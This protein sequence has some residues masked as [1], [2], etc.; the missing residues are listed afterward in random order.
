M[1]AA[2]TEA[3]APTQWPVTLDGE[4]L[5]VERILQALNACALVD[6][7]GDAPSSLLG[8]GGE[9]GVSETTVEKITEKIVGT[10]A[11]RW[12]RQAA[13][14][15]LLTICIEE[16]GIDIPLE[17]IQQASDRYREQ[18]GLRSVEDT[19]AW[20]E[21]RGLS[22][23]TWGD[24]V[25]TALATDELVRL[26]TETGVETW[27]AQ[28]RRSLDRVELA[29]LAVTDAGMAEEIMD[30]FEDG[31]LS[32]AEAV[33]RFHVDPAARKRG[34]YLGW[35]D[36]ARVPHE[37]EARLFGAAP[38]ELVGPVVSAEDTRLYRV[39]ASDLA[40]Y[41]EAHRARVARILFADWWQ[42]QCGRL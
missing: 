35:C 24:C 19:R 20:L 16:S 41:D 10:T 37:A 17:S 13:D 15:V 42:G 6:F 29:C 28:N 25:E 31:D 27:Y 5:P 3:L 1:T 39:L 4:P 34:G 23:D 7:T 36:R 14:A 30:Q 18:N 11:K 33:A 2:D 32:F 9:I 12:L 38:G 26:K 22:L 8:P 40:E 21:V